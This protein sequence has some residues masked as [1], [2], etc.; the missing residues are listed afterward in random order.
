MSKDKKLFAQKIND[1]VLDR[2][3][4]CL[5]LRNKQLTVTGSY[6]NKGDL[7][8]E[9]INDYYYRLQGQTKDAGTV[10]K[11]NTYVE[12]SVKAKFDSNV[13]K[14]LEQALF[15]LTRNSKMMEMM[16]RTTCGTY[17]EQIKRRMA[18]GRFSKEE[19]EESLNDYIENQLFKP[20]VFLEVL[21]SKLSEENENG[22]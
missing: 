3:E 15:I 19:A 1:E 9:I 17:D 5:E 18:D 4:E 21:D 6:I 12:D 14:V 2:F 8:E 11:I 13:I 7:L 22:E 10:D 16:I 20:A